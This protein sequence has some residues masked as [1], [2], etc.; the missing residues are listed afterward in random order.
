MFS[1]ILFRLKNADMMTRSPPHIVSS[2]IGSSI[3]LDRLGDA[4]DH[5]RKMQAELSRD[6][7]FPV[8]TLLSPDYDINGIDAWIS[9]SAIQ[10]HFFDSATPIVVMSL[11]GMPLTFSNLSIRP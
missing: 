3:R 7:V 8:D 5:E 4:V 11:A 2:A 10:E 1:Q 6:F 9:S